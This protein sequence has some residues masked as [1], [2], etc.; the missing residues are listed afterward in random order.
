MRKRRTKEISRKNKPV[1]ARPLT[2]EFVNSL[3]GCLGEGSLALDNILLEE[4]NCPWEA[5]N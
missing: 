3:R 2:P 1:A 4:R 5:S